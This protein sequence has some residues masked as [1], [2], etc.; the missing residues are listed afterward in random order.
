M[1]KIADALDPKGAA[2]AGKALPQE[3]PVKLPSTATPRA[4]AEL[5]TSIREITRF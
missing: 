2:S 1:G 5:G 4:E 3:P